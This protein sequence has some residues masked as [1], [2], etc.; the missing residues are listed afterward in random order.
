VQLLA[1]G[2]YTRVRC[3]FGNIGSGIELASKTYNLQGAR[4]TCV[5]AS[6][7]F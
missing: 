3:T 6:A 7:F 5:A 4:L 2:E 1:E